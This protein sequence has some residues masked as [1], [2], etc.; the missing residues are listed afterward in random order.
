[1]L[2]R[3]D[4]LFAN[5]LDLKRV[6]GVAPGAGSEVMIGV[7]HARSEEELG[8]EMQEN[9][10]ATA[11]RRENSNQLAPSIVIGSGSSDGGWEPPM[12]GDNDSKEILA[13]PR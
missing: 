12:I 3:K 7:E 11:I 13:V 6:V 1:M 2:T 8:K 10:A 5:S 4:L 9:R